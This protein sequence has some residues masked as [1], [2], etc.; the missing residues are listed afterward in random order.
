ML[1]M[2]AAVSVANVYFAQPLLDA[3]AHDFALS[4]AWAG[5]IIGATQAGCAL[6]LVLVVPLGDR[7]P[8][9]PLLLAQLVLLT[10]ALLGVSLAQTRWPLL[11]GML[12]VGL[13]GTAMT[14]GLIAC[15]AALASP[16]E[17]GRVL[18]VV[19][20]GVVIGLLLAR[21][22]AGG[23]AD[24]WGW[25]AVYAVS[26]SVSAVMLAALWRWLPTPAM[27]SVPMH[28]GALLRSM[29]QLLLSERVLQVRGLIA[30]LM[31]AAFSVFWS[32][33]A[34]ALSAPPYAFS[35][36]G[37]G[38][39]G[40]VGAVGALAAARAGR[41]ADRGW[42]Q[43]AT[44]AALGLLLIAWLPLGWG[45]HHLAWL[46]VGVILLDLGGQAVHVLNQSLI[47]RLHPEAHSRLVGAYMLFYAAGSGLGAMAS[48][49]MYARAGW[50]GVCL[51]GA[52]I[53]LAALGFW[54]ASAAWMRRPEPEAR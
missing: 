47:F 38:A 16:S 22:V 18:G 23:I 24:A 46:V 48:T 25:R 52:A 15:A 51:L 53:S 5:G 17:R 44:A 1:A 8:R 32:A 21:T 26:A 30:F 36:A 45:L 2:C 35:P 39:F 50:S 42:A 34:L 41:L 54:A 12:G 43:P 13:L 6:A 19:Q 20:G 33:L 3:L 37:I 9:K 40:L 28:Y 14:Q 31:F 29:W 49:A 7:W 4:E 10:A 11:L 27:A